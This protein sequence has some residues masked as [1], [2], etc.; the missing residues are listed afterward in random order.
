MSAGKTNRTSRSLVAMTARCVVLACVVL[1][2]LPQPDSWVAAQEHDP[3]IHVVVN[4]VQLNVAV[5]DREG[6]YITGL[7]PQDF[8]ITEDGIPEKLAPFSA[9]NESVRRVGDSAEATKPG[10][11][12]DQ[13]APAATPA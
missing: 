2:L 13:H 8:F 6:R 7:R 3:H 1:S 5:T 9:G 11:L 10:R 4:L 12:T